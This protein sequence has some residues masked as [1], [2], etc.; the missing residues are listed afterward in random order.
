MLPLPPYWPL[1]AAT[2]V[3]AQ[4]PQLRQQAP[5]WQELGPQEVPEPTSRPA[6]HEP[7]KMAVQAAVAG[8]QQ[9]ETETQELAPQEVPVPEVVPAAHEPPKMALQAPVL[10]LQQVETETQAVAQEVPCPP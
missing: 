3:M 2:E 7:P 6:A 8:L 10:L 4:P 5:Y 1:H 9:V